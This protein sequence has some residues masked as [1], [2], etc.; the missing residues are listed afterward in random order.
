MSMKKNIKRMLPTKIKTY[1]KKQIGQGNASVQPVEYVVNIRDVNSLKDKA[2]II[3]G[4]T[5]AIG[6]AI[7][8]QLYLEGAIVGICGR[9]ITKVNQLIKRF[10]NENITCAGKLIPICID[11][12]DENSIENGIN[13]FV[14]K[15]GKIDAFIN[16]AGGGAREKSKVLW[17]Q[18]IKVIDQVINT[19]LR[20]S[21]LCA[22]KAAQIMVPQNNGVILNMSSVV[23]INGKKE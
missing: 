22:R 20:G 19:N 4:S 17:E 18:D 1:I 14:E 5:G 7:A 12:T 15:V 9:N 13:A 8:H 16:N 10:E 3:T 6:S 11:V 21:I 2:I 23:G